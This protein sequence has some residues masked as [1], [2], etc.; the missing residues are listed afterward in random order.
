MICPCLSLHGC[1]VVMSKRGYF[2][3]AVHSSAPSYEEVVLM[4]CALWIRRVPE[5][6][7]LCT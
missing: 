5:P 2:S 1:G 7:V 3:S 6:L 4:R